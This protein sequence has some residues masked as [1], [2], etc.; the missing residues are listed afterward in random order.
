MVEI[1]HTCRNNSRN[2]NKMKRVVVLFIVLLL[3]GA[4][5]ISAQSLSGVSI[6]GIPVIGSGLTGNYTGDLGTTGD[7]YKYEWMYH[8]SRAV[9]SSTTT[10]YTIMAADNGMQIYFK[11]SILDASDVVLV[12]DSSSAVQVNS[13]PVA[14][15]I[16]ISGV[17]R[18][19]MTLTGTYEYSDI[20][21]DIKST[22][23][24][25]Y[26]WFYGTSVT[27]A[28]SNQIGGANSQTYTL[29]NTY[30]GKYIGFAV[31]PASTTG[32][33]PGVE[34]QTVIWIGPITANNPPVADG[35]AISG[36][37]TFNVND[38]FIGNYDF[39]DAEGDAEDG[40]VYEW[41]RS[42]D[43]DILNG[44]KI[45]GAS[46]IAYKLAL[47][48]TGKYIFFKVTPKAKTGTLTGSQVVTAGS[49]P[50]NTPPYAA[51]VSIAGDAIVDSVLT[52]NY[53]FHDGDHNP[54]G[55]S[56]FRWLRNGTD[57]I[58]GA[59]SDTYTLTTDD[60]DLSIKFEVTPVSSVGF[61]NTG[62]VVRSSL[63][64]PV[65]DPAAAL[66]KAVDVCISGTRTNSASLTGKYKYENKY[67]EHNSVYLWLRENVVV[68]SGTSA[69]NKSYTL[70]A[71]DT[72]KSIRFA[73]IPKNNKSKV[74]DTAFSDPLAIF[75]LS[76]E[77]F[78]AG[79][80]AQPLSASPSGGIFYGE[81]VTNG[82][83][84]PS[85]V[86]YLNS[87]FMVN[88]QLTINN[89]SNS[90]QQ[91]VSRSLEVKG[92][93]M[94]FD[95]FRDIYCQ[96]GGND[97]IYVKSIPAGAAIIGFQM[98]NPNGTV[99]TLN[100]STLIINPGEMNAGDKVDYLK[101]IVFSGGAFIELTR[102]FLIDSIAQ[103]TIQ[104]L[105]TGAV[106]CNNSIPYELFVSHPGG[107]FAGPVVDRI[108]TPSLTLGDATVKYT[109]TTKRGCTSSVTVPVKIN[110][111]PSVAFAAADSCISSASDTTRFINM[112][113]SDDPVT[114]WLWDFSDAGGSRT[115]T[116]ETPGYLYKTSG[117]HKVTLTATTSNNCSLTHEETIDLGVKPVAD[118]Y[119]KSECYH[120]NDSIMLFDTTFSTTEI[121]SRTWNFFDGDS[122]H[123]VKNPKYPKKSTGYLPVEY[124]VKTSYTN[125]H[126][127]VYKKIFIRPSV[128][129]ATDDYFQNFENGKGGW[130]KDY[131]M[132]NSWVFGKP[133]R[134]VIN[135]AAS[136]DSA[137][138]TRYTL[139]N[140]KVESSSIVSP[141]FD[142]SVSKRPMIRLKL[143]KRFDRNRDG[144]VLQYKIGDI[145]EWQPVGTLDD[146]INWFNST[147]IKGRPGGD[148]IGWTTAGSQDT[149]WIES[150]HSLDDLTGGKD[151]KFRIAYGSDGTSQDNDGIAF[152]DI[153]I[154]ERTRHVL[155]E[156]FANTSYLRSSEATA[157]VN[158][159]ANN[160]REDVINIQYHTNFPG[161]DPFYDNNPGDASARVLFYGLIKAP[162]S[163]IDGGSRKD[164]ANI[165]DYTIA[166]I[167]SNDV[168]RRSLI[169]PLFDI[170][171]NSTVSGGLLS[172]SGQ[173]TALENINSDNL[174]IFL[175]VTEK[176]NNEHTGANGE[177]MFY[178][179]FRKFIPDAGGISLKK[180]WTPGETYTL[181]ER[182]WPIDKS[183]NSADI[184]VIAFI[185]NS[186][187]KELFQAASEIKQ[188]LVV[189][190]GDLFQGKVAEF[191]LFPNPATDKLTIAFSKPLARETDIRIYDMRGIVISSYK[192]GSGLSEYRIDDAG[193]PGG[194]YLVRVSSA[195]ID[196]G[197][198]KLIISSK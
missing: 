196:L 5:R 118:F 150:R 134:T 39:S 124:I 114:S 191:A 100:D 107:A 115:S 146:G 123:V 30:I 122:L 140:Q 4:A 188:N 45:D 158:T 170:S 101:F 190:I 53:T 92:V 168:I 193:L 74:G 195:G 109:Y 130:E 35:V 164:F 194:I 127:T 41:W 1:L 8:P 44:E 192:A 31:T 104:N 19:G 142:F 67:D 2:K 135:T 183:L 198:R 59:T 66:P 37:G 91:N 49:G 9:L 143:W 162:Y 116:K 28:G 131:E 11:V 89:P 70:T 111:A 128:S 117:F 174:N 84:V 160:N 32:S 34:A 144:A 163:F 156:H 112:T 148:Q 88:Y 81:G 3:L 90:C 161:S 80:G 20:D 10:S 147:L 113:V 120:P 83:F 60:V 78:S 87:P 181:T 141:C 56:L 6:I 18:S 96:N 27:G 106:F 137:W 15:Y 152:D 51:G 103:V 184:E 197:F 136:G 13:Y 155:L 17:P 58:P 173:I 72:A 69:G 43:T 129:L 157:M 119:W 110:A 178:N 55:T 86:D 48:D 52:G 61:P 57:P 16:S 62:N 14:S 133:D 25:A 180:T 65:T 94:Y 64:G 182:T 108:F 77:S 177:T 50:V 22:G 154:G 46:L 97:T 54:E 145:G 63:F 138:F 29:T 24:T 73:V 71:A 79:E 93:D 68:K 175:A 95:S 42:P 26:K 7:H 125:C 165:F 23:S 139:V 47:S 121:L 102:S 187:T 105:D 153:W 167:D 85:S 126:D 12:K 172:I 33:T 149:K 36:P 169:N 98:S 132:K 176:E 166:D 189:G 21:G 179:I 185:Q 38:V 40:S 186:V 82:N 171:L 75:T 159:I 151:V 76:R 99:G